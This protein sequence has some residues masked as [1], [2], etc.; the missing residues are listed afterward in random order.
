MKFLTT[1][2]KKHQYQLARLH[3]IADGQARR[4]VVQAYVYAAAKWRSSGTT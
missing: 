2:A 1:P 3:C 4:K